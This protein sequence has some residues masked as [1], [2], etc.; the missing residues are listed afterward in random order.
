MH[1]RDYG[2]HKTDLVV[3]TQV[4]PTFLSARSLSNQE[5][6]KYASLSGLLDSPVSISPGL[7]LHAHA[8]MPGVLFVCF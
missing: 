5:F 1:T 8:T 4:P 7:R 6:I 2:G 3:I